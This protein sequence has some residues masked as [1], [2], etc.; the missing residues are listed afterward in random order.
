[1]AFCCT[2]VCPPPPTANIPERLPEMRKVT[3]QD[4]VH[5]VATGYKN[6]ALHSMGF[7]KK[8]LKEPTKVSKPTSYLWRGFR[9]PNKSSMRTAPG[10][11]WGAPNI[12][13][14]TALP[15]GVSPAIDQEADILAR[16]DNDNHF[17][18]FFAKKLIQTIIVFREKM[19]RLT[20]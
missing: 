10:T 2:T 4:G 17:A 5:F 12:H 13:G 19:T 20:G 8:L 16:V 18:S 7:I 14:D 11:Q 3:A 15:L 6:L 1:M 9:S